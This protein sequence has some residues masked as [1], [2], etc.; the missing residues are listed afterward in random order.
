MAI[1]YS[2]TPEKPSV[3]ISS[4]LFIGCFFIKLLTAGHPIII[5]RAIIISATE[6]GKNND[7]RSVS[8]PPSTRLLLVSMKTDKTIKIDD[9]NIS[10]FLLSIICL[11][12][13]LLFFV[14][15][16]ECRKSQTLTYSAKPRERK[17]RQRSP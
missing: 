7:P 13:E 8:T 5:D 11:Q 17:S 4:S 10:A 16:F 12:C 9:R 6:R 15:V 14:L 2:R 3:A 1:M